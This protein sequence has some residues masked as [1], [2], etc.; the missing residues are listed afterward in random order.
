MV[1]ISF[2]TGGVFPSALKIAKTI[3]IFK[4]KDPL[5]VSSLGKTSI[6]CISLERD[7]I[8]HFWGQGW[9]RCLL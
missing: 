3:Q 8:M 7:L 6:Y 5:E 4:N 2:E 1:N 9:H